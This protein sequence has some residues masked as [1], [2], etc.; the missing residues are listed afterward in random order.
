M[1]PRVSV[2]EGKFGPSRQDLEIDYSVTAAPRDSERNRIRI[3]WDESRNPAEDE[4]F[5][6]R[7]QSWTAYETEKAMLY[8]SKYAIKALGKKEQRV[9]L[10]AGERVHSGFSDTIIAVRSLRARASTP[11]SSDSASMAVNIS[12]EERASDK[13]SDQGE[14]LIDMDHGGASDDII[15]WVCQKLHKDGT[16]DYPEVRIQHVYKDLPKPRLLRSPSCP[17]LGNGH[18]ELDYFDLGDQLDSISQCS[19]CDSLFNFSSATDG[20]S[21]SIHSSL[22]EASTTL[23]ESFFETLSHLERLEERCQRLEEQCQRC[24]ARVR[25]EMEKA[26]ITNRVRLEREWMCGNMGTERLKS[27]LQRYEC[28]W[29]DREAAWK[30]RR[31]A[32]RNRRREGKWGPLWSWVDDKIAWVDDKFCVYR[33]LK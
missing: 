6:S 7:R 30:E 8:S 18:S 4:P 22:T 14:D 16:R 12:S 24:E 26:K 21:S 27:R 20:E 17:A 3:L 10:G 31:R 32:W 33:I 11:G 15:I 25:W 19:C 29:R 13:F 2:E 5:M 28:K 23:L 1:N 9:E